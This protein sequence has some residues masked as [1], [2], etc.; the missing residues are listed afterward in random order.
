M[1]I[2]IEDFLQNEFPDN[3][4]NGLKD[5]VRKFASGYD[6]AEHYKSE[7]FCPAKKNGKAKT[8]RHTG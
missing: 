3:K 5:S 4:Y 7:Q 1:N 2:S 6:T 8:C